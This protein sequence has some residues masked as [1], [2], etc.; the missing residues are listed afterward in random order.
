VGE[1][2][3]RVY[4]HSNAIPMSVTRRKDSKEEHI[5][6]VVD[7]IHK[8]RIG[9]ALSKDEIRELIKAFVRGDVPDYQMSALAMAIVFQGMNTEETTE[10]TL[11]MAESGHQMDLSDIAGVKVDKHSTGG[12]GDT[13]TL[14]LA[15]LVASVGVPIAKMS[16]RGLGHTGGTIDKLESIPGFSVEMTMD[17]FKEQVRKVGVAV[18]AQT[19]DLA[20][21]DKSLYALRD[22]TD[23]VESIPLIAS[24]IMSKKLASGAD[25]IVLDVKVG[26]GAFMKTVD[27]ARELAKTMVDIGRLANRKT[28]AV[29]TRM[30]EPLGR[31]VGNALEVREAIQ[32]LR[33]QGPEDLTELCLVLGAEMVVQGGKAKDVAEARKLLEDAI[34]SGDA[35]QKCKEFILAQGG[36]ARVVD[37]LSLLP[38]APVVAYFEAPTD[39]VIQRIHAEAFGLV[40]MRLGAGR[41]QKADVINPAVGLVL[42]R[43][44]GQTVVRGEP[45]VEIHAASQED[46]E[47]AKRELAACIEIGAGDPFEPALILEVVRASENGVS[48][49]AYDSQTYSGDRSR[50]GD[51][52]Q[53]AGDSPI[54]VKSQIPGVEQLLD[55]AKRARERSYSPYSKFPVGAALRLSN[56]KIVLGANVENASFGLTNCAER[57]AI[58]QAVTEHR[59][60]KDVSVDSIAIVA[61]S[62]GPVAPCGACRQVL[63]EFC[64]PDTPVVLGDMK[65]NT[66]YTTVGELLPYTFQAGQMKGLEDDHE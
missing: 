64:K 22:V 17:A 62:D 6:R 58:F 2:L 46:A 12:V 28:V 41:A 4:I 47:R 49:A 65:G 3:D 50:A 63:A 52:S 56:G 10:L 8:K 27:R 43:K 20:P 14:V 59:L 60:G 7:I 33:G 66:R 42:V 54:G 24:S 57:T 1:V 18:A 26:D 55:G 45:L 29:L 37:D 13:T 25:A 44:T 15:P 61:D 5:M 34:R 9:Q 40:A 36:D 39:G 48:T 31:A 35:I 32:T 30:D 21:A 38:K 19:G 11:A 51:T 23:T 53:A 16:G